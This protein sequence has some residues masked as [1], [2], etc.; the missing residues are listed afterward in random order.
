MTPILY[1]SKMGEYYYEDTN[2]PGTG[3]AKKFPYA[4]YPS[5][6]QIEFMLQLTPE[7]I[8]KAKG[9]DVAAMHPN[10]VFITVKNIASGEAVLKAQIDFDK[11]GYARKLL[12]IPDLS[13][14]EYQVEYQIGAYHMVSPEKFTR[15]HFAFEKTKYGETHKVYPPF[16]PVKVDNN[17]VEVVGRKYR[18]NAF[19]MPESVISLGRELL[20][21]PISL[22]GNT[23]D[24][25][26]IIWENGSVSGEKNYDDEA[27]FTSKISSPVIVVNSKAIVWEDG[28]IKLNMTLS[29][30]A[31]ANSIKTL[32]LVIPLKDKEMPLLHF[33]AD[34]SMR[35]NYGGKTPR[36]GKPKWYNESWDRWVPQRYKISSP[37]FD[38][39]ELWNSGQSNQWGNEFRAD[40]RPYCPYIWMGA[41]ERGFSF[42]MES[43]K[44]FVTDY[45]TPLQKIIRSGDSIRI[46][47][48]VIKGPYNLTKPRT[49][50][51]G[52]MASPGKP[53]PKNPVT[54]P[55]SSGIGPVVCWGGW[56]CSSK[57]PALK[58]WS[59]VD[60]IQ[61]IRK[62]GEITPEDKAWINA[63]GEEIE[64]AYPTRGLFKKPFKKG[65]WARMAT[66]FAQRAAHN[67]VGKINSG[68]YFE[69]H[70]TDVE[71]EEWLV[72]QDEWASAE[73]NRFQ[74][75]DAH[76]GVASPSYQDFALYNA[77]EWLKRGV[78]LYFDNTFPK[79]NY[80][81]RFGAAYFG[82][83]GKLLYGVTYFAQR[84]YYRR[85]YK[86]L[87]EY[88]EK[89]GGAFGPLDFTI[90]MTNTNTVPLNT[91]ATAS[92]DFEQR[93]YTEDPDKVPA[94]EAQA[95]RYT[96]KDKNGYQLP[97]APDY[98]RAVT[99]GGQTG[100]KPMALDYVS[101]HG[102][103]FGEK[104]HTPAVQM[105]NWG[106]HR[107]HSIRYSSPPVRRNNLITVY[108]CDKV[109]LDFG[110]GTDKVEEY[111][112]WTA[113]SPFRVDDDR[114]KWL[115]LIS[116]NSSI[117]DYGLI[118]MQSYSRTDSIDAN[119]TFPNAARLVDVL[120][121]ENIPVVNGVAI[122]KMPKE[123][124]T[125]LFKAYK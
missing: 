56:R 120:T 77:N 20:N 23:V 75:K 40:H 102:R 115:V 108:D 5:H 68:T 121:N 7:I 98:L 59:I 16:Q 69:E 113:N 83:N 112:Y 111:N 66:I 35:L 10:N 49:I 87:S 81:Y 90:H 51:V 15:K 19:G 14:G 9:G 6:N 85:I 100:V 106:M 63:K 116:K 73:F 89:G 109:L 52:F 65:E 26:A 29:P 50:T 47:V 103:I 3:I 60:K 86:L 31:E 58:D 78:S 117:K 114:I 79:R 124:S 12:K 105:R 42:F 61:E 96:R 99:I 122:I 39:G 123:F 101:G 28:C 17:T 57:Y 71:D 1:A 110:Y 46:E 95:P 48:D 70:S 82:D 76:W 13:D 32:K 34:N 88:N 72:F 53:K 64:K 107:V 119:V 21:A 33:I 22:A 24:G 25:K 30:G 92:L 125:R 45:K 11:N 93:G 62:I 37:G 44:G 4:Y 55:L 91:W 41:E 74:E 97:W 2:L 80:N 38:D 27:T 8:S 43:E 94:V 67:R 18:F 54:S 84:E 104:Y 118:I 36:G